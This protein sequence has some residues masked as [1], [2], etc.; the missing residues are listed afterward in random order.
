MHRSTDPLRL[1]EAAAAAPLKDPRDS[2][3]GGRVGVLRIGRSARPHSLSAGPRCAVQCTRF[4]VQARHPVP[5]F[6]PVR[7]A[8]FLRRRGRCVVSASD[9][10]RRAGEEERSQHGSAVLLV[11][12]GKEHVGL[13]PTVPPAWLT[14]STSRARFIRALSAYSAEFVTVASASGSPGDFPTAAH[15]AA[16]GSA[17]PRRARRRG[18]HPVRYPM[19]LSPVEGERR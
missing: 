16:D 3:S 1:P 13:R 6:L 4:D 10:D 19:Q 17:G 12:P 7:S 15:P 5:V 14:L 9:D 8:A 11:S 2:P 18:L